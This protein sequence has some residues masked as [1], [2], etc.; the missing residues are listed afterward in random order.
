VGV[1]VEVPRAQTE[2]SEALVRA[3]PSWVLDYR[4]CLAVDAGSGAALGADLM[5]VT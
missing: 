4:S 3:I 1:V 2:V 5:Y